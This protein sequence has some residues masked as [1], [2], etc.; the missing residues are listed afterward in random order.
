MIIFIITVA[1]LALFVL[2]LS[3]T[4]IFKGRNIQG[5]VG[6]NEQMRKRG[7]ECTSAAIRREQAELEGRAFEGGDFMCNDCCSTCGK[8]DD[9]QSCER[10]AKS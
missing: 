10:D 1:A 2:G 5:D 9:S 4:L 7:L 8:T 3:L 6:G